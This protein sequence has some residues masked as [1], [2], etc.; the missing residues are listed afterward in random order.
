MEKSNQADMAPLA[1]GEFGIPC[2]W[3]F[4]NSS[5]APLFYSDSDCSLVQTGP[6]LLNIV[7]DGSFLKNALLPNSNITFLSNTLVGSLGLHTHALSEALVVQNPNNPPTVIAVVALPRTI[8]V[9]QDLIMDFSS[10]SGAGGR[11][12]S[13]VVFKSNSSALTKQLSSLSVFLK[14]GSTLSIVIPAANITKTG[15]YTGSVTF[16]NVFNQSSSVSWS[17]EK[18]SIASIPNVVMPPA[19][20]LQNLDVSTSNF[21]SAQ[22]LPSCSPSVNR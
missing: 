17:F 14:N 13:N 18:K 9:C 16:L 11:D 15:V 12:W 1:I 21:I 10:S 19:S 6:N 22:V 4:V 8:S 2:S 20:D 5:S 3:V 7:L